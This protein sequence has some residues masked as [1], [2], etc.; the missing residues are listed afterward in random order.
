[1]YRSQKKQNYIE[2]DPEEMEEEML[3]GSQPI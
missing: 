3:V 1:M 2:Y